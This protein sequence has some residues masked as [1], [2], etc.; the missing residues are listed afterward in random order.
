LT[1]FGRLSSDTG[2]PDW[3]WAAM[4]SLANGI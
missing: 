1:A 3:L 4:A 2:G